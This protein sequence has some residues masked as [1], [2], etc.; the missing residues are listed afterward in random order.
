MINRIL[1]RI[2][3]VQLFFAYEKNNAKSVDVAEKELFHSIEQT[4]SLYHLLLLLVPEITFLAQKKLDAAKNKL[5]PTNEDLNPN[6]R[7]IDNAF[8]AQLVSNEA[9]NE[10]TAENKISW[11][12]YPTTVKNLFEALQNSDFYAEYMAMPSTSY[13]ADRDLWRKFFKKCIINNEELIATLED[14]SIYWNDDLEIVAS[15][16]QKTIKRFEEENGSKQPLL[17]MF[18]DEEDKEFA[19]KLYRM[20]ILHGDEYRKLIDEHTRNWEVDRIAFMDVVIMQLAIAELLNFQTIP[21]NVTLNEYIEISKVYS[22]ERS[23]TFINGVLD[24]VVNQLTKDKK[25]I[26]AKVVSTIQK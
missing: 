2:K 18:K 25:L 21:V 19:K 11:V 8:T 10:Y 12:N 13:E 26:K 22:T 5:R 15:F 24:N 7:F 3:L 16:V 14:M 23:G 4:Y 1:L 17:P 20:A 6:T 9:F